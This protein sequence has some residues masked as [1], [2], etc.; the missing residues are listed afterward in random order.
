MKFS[1]ADLAFQQDVRAFIQANLPDDVRKK[2]IHG[3]EVTKDDYTRWHKTLYRKG[4]IA[5]NWPVEHGGCGWS[6]IQRYIFDEECGLAGAPRLSPFGLG[7]VGPVIMHFGTEAQKK[8]YLPNILSGEETWC[9]GYS[10]PGSG[11]DLASL[12]TR[13]ERKGD[14]YL[15]NGSKLWTSLAHHAD[16][17]FCLVRTS[18]EKKKQD[19]ISFLV[20][21]IKDQP[22]IEIRPLITLNGL[23][24]VNQVFFTD[25]KVPLDSLIGEEG[26]GWTIAKYLLEHERVSGGGVGALKTALQR[27]KDIASAE[28][29]D[30]RPLIEDTDFRRRVA[31]AEIEL[32]SVEQTMLRAL[33]AF[34]ADK[35]IGAVSS[36]IK[37][38]RSEVEQM[39]SELGVMAAHY[40]AMPYSVASLRDGWNEE[41]IGPEDA[42]SLTP[43]YMF[44]RAASIYSGSNEI[45]RNIIAKADLRLS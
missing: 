19:G 39:I 34:S 43:S 6:V 16:L 29:S 2:V 4:W 5:P 37:I 23:R 42:N 36:L 21:R 13:A 35:S 12:Q 15:I 25:V 33:A 10:E 45:Q 3:N 30:G 20:F 22:G 18:I 28:L 9:Q 24:H 14:H 26:K 44:L 41:P 7:M 40:Y 32:I 1:Q 8:R 38:R 17:I 31:Q 27:V 11:S